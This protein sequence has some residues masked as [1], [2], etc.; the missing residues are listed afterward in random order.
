MDMGGCDQGKGKMRSMEDA[1]EEKG[2]QGK[3][4]SRKGRDDKEGERAT[5][6]G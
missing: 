6:G 5:R 2:N 4:R 1:M 3:V